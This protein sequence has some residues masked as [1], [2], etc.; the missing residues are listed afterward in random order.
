MKDKQQVLGSPEIILSTDGLVA[1]CRSGFELLEYTVQETTQ[2]GNSTSS[3]RK[4]V[5]QPVPSEGPLH[6]TQYLSSTTLFTDMFSNILCKWQKGAGGSP[7][8]SIKC[9]SFQVCS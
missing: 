6:D 5:Q 7:P 2:K 3:S 4:V 9:F 1:N 8:A